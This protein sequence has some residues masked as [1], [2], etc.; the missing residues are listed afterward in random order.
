M[1][2]ERESFVAMVVVDRQ[3]EFIFH[4]ASVT[5]HVPLNTLLPSDK[6]MVGVSTTMTQ[7]FSGQHWQFFHVF[8]GILL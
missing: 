3:P 7:R 2:V 8:G 5:H 6:P 4:S 1:L